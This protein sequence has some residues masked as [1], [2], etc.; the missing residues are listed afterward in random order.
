[1]IEDLYFYKGKYRTEEGLKRALIKDKKVWTSPKQN[2]YLLVD[3]FEYYYDFEYLKELLKDRNMLDEKQLKHFRKWLN[4]Q[5]KEGLVDVLHTSF[6]HCEETDGMGFPDFWEIL[7]SIIDYNDIFN[8]EYCDDF[9]EQVERTFD[10]YIDNL[11][12]DEFKELEKLPENKQYKKAMNWR[13]QQ[14]NE[15]KRKMLNESKD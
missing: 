7:E 4:Q 12:E 2:Y 10:N 1:M 11:S 9:V 15:Y 14:Y 3:Q 8:E 5:Q 6:Y 13:V